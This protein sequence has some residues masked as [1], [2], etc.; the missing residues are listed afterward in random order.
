MRV[1]ALLERTARRFRAAKLSYGHG[2]RN[3][4][5]EAGWLISS[6]LGY[7]LEE[8]VP[9]AKLR[10]IEALAARRIRERK[11]LAYLL[12]EAWLGEHAF[13][14]DERT[15]VPRSFIAEML[16]ERL[17]PWLAREQIGRAHV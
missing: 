11:P 1:S 4:R 16:R 10:R 8:E 9:P 6:V 17:S 12:N 14:V 3:A 5:E 2:T 13:Y 7:L 15:L